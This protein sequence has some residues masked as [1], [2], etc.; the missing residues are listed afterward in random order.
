MNKGWQFLM[1]FLICFVVKSQQFDVHVP[2]KLEGANDRIDTHRKG[3]A[4]LLFVLDDQMSESANMN[5]ELVNHAFNFGVSMTQEGPFEGTT[6][7]DIYRQRVSE[8]FNFV[9]LGFYWGARDEKR[10]LSGFNKRM[11]DKISWAVRNKMKIK[12]HP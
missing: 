3:K 7:Q 9:T 2:W 5:L 10:G 1:T 6:Y 11:D 12:G 8:V 4:K